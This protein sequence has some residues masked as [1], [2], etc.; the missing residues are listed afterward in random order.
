MKIKN[1]SGFTK[2][3]EWYKG[4]LHSHTTNS[5]GKLEPCESVRL[6]KEH[7]YNFLCLS[8]HDLYTDYRS[9]FNDDDF[10]I[11]P[12]LEASAVLLDEAGEKCLKVH[13]MIGI[14]GTEKMQKKALD[15]DN[16][17][18]KHM[19]T[20]KIPVYYGKWNGARVAAELNKSLRDRGLLTIYNHPIWSRVEPR[21][22]TGLKQ[23]AGIE[24]FNYNT[25]N[26][27]GTGYDTVFWDMFLR[28]GKKI[29]GFAAD[30]NH[31]PGTFDDACGGYICVKAESLTHDNIIR[32]IK[33][34]NYYSSSG[35]SI[36]DWGIK[37]GNVYVNCSP[38][39][40]VNFIAGNN[41]NA[42]TTVM[43]D[44]LDET[45]KEASFTLKGDESYVRVECT[46]KFGRTAWTN[47]IFIK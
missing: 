11:I 19:E 28:A 40:R 25:V 21:E 24:V 38:V 31:N 36:Y 7:G 3:G 17:L 1:I 47:P 39:N 43:C 27:S 15:K 46:D 29:N 13:H 10:I 33:K 34:G 9:E 30:D 12:G 23:I 2:D 14:L 44:T 41:V 22:V 18:Y 4:N 5:D 35:P 6:F 42:G 37:D 16:K 8:E 45:I 26:E 20:H 32:A